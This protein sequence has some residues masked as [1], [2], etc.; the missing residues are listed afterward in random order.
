M[1][2]EAV[3][4]TNNLLCLALPGTVTWVSPSKSKVKVKVH[5]T[6][7]QGIY[8]YSTR[9]SYKFTQVLGPCAEL[10]SVRREP[11]SLT[12]QE[13]CMVPLG[14]SYQQR[15]SWIV[16]LGHREWS[17]ST[18]R[19]TVPGCI[20]YFHPS[21]RASNSCNYWLRG[22]ILSLV[23]LKGM[24]S[25]DISLLE[26]SHTNL[27]VRCDMRMRAQR[28]TWKRRRILLSFVL[29]FSSQ[30]YTLHGQSSVLQIVLWV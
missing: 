10:K 22:V 21:H 8:T 30:E 29:A 20:P 11:H 19:A 6:A 3:A 2:A 16:E 26:R 23:Q 13:S 17:Y 28:L 4:W 25:L 1:N 24:I 5:Y 18:P 27:W 12:V 7:P 14:T 15:Q 9:R